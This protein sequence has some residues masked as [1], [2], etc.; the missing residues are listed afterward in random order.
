M[1]SKTSS[2]RQKVCRD[3]KGMLW[4]QKLCHGVKT[5][6]PIKYVL[7]CLCFKNILGPILH[8]Y[9]VSF[10]SYQWLCV[11]HNFGDFELFLWFFS[12]MQ[13]SYPA[14][15]ISSFVAIGQYL[16]TLS[17]CDIGL[18]THRYTDT[19]TDKHQHYNKPRFVRLIKRRIILS[20]I[21]IMSL[22]RTFLFVHILRVVSVGANY[23]CHFYKG[24]VWN[25]FFSCS[26]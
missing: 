14:T 2:W 18:R 11:F 21:M 16:T 1:M 3:I 10:L 24:R 9:D 6:S 8:F 20:I 17:M 25:I 13:I 22:G 12:T 23:F 19:N 7:V 15:S 5:F 26:F 4:R